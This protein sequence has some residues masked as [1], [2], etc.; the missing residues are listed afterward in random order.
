MVVLAISKT[1]YSVAIYDTQL[2]ETIQTLPSHTSEVVGG[3]FSPIEPLMATITNSGEMTLWALD[4]GEIL[5]QFQA[6]FRQTPVLG[7]CLGFTSDGRTLVAAG[8]YIGKE[9][10]HYSEIRAW[11]VP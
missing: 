10:N 2:G 3:C 6:A 5:L 8:G 4:T 7:A 1:D 11:R 9:K